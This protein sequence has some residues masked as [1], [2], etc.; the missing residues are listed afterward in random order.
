MSSPWPFLHFGGF[1]GPALNLH[2]ALRARALEGPNVGPGC[3]GRGFA[4]RFDARHP[5]CRAS[6]LLA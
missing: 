6:S 3:P 1:T 2:Q 5:S 4:Y